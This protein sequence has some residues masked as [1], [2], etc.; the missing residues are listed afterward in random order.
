MASRARRRCCGFTLIESAV[1]AGL[2]GIFVAI[3][4]SRL[5]TYQAE[6]ERV[7]AEQLV[8]TLRTALQVRAAKAVIE[9]GQQGLR[10]L[11]DENPVGWL[12]EKP[13]NYLGEYYAPDTEELPSGNWYFDRA[14]RSLVYL[15]ENTKSFSIQTS[16][17]LKFKVK[18]SRLPTPDRVD[19]RSTTSTGLVFDQ[20]ADRNAVNNKQEAVFVP[21]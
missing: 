19:R 11:L 6:A 12:S 2:L 17:F 5:L 10:A 18:L 7:A 15:F 20:V 21:H 14:D 13:A 3:L 4:A 16:N 1:V 9:G 8:G